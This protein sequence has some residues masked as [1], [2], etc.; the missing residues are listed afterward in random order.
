MAGF[1]LT[2]AANILKVFYLPPV[3]EQLNNS[4]ILL[5]RIDRDE[6]TQD[7]TGTSFT[8]PLHTGRNASAGVGRAENGTLPTAGAQGYSK[9]VVPNKYLYGRIQVSGPVIAATKNNAGAFVRAIESEMKGLLRD[10]KRS[11][12][13]QLH[14]DGT[15]AL[16]FWTETDTSSGGFVDDGNGFPFVHLPSGATTCDLIDASDH[17]TELGTN[18][19][20]TLGAETSTAYNITWT[21]DESGGGTTADGDYLV[22]ADT[23]GYQMMGLAGIVSAA[24]PPLL[25]GGLHG[26]TTASTWWSAQVVGSDAS[27]TDLTFGNMQKVFSK[28]ASNSDYSEKDIKFL[29]CSYGVRDKYVQLC[30]DER[31]FFNTMTLD[32]GFEAVEYNGK[33]IVPDAQCKRG[34]LY[35]I[36]PETLRLFRSSDFDWMDNDGNV[37]SRVANTDAYEATLFHYGDLGCVS[38]NGNGVLVGINE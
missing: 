7:V 14:S 16:A 27:H 31:R 28:I 2:A 6:T 17:S 36:V 5:S 22:L 38:R 13:R 3:R 26:I 4:S 33:P 1:D 21:G 29:I 20:V 30:T 25:T 12:N 37:F 15:D 9:A 18:L 32:G 10:M 23:L 8:V 11:V 34:R 35:F 19:V 24:N